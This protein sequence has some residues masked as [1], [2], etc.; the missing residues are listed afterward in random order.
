MK[1][2]KILK[3]CSDDCNFIIKLNNNKSKNMQK[4]T[5]FI[6][7]FNTIGYK[8]FVKKYNKKII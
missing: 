2:R 8:A 5:R 4:I 1:K 3:I 7:E 6:N